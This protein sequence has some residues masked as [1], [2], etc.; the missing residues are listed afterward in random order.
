[1][2]QP[3]PEEQGEV[4]AKEG[5]V[6]FFDILGYGSYLKNDP[7]VRSKQALRVLLDIKAELPASIK[8]R[9][10]ETL[11]SHLSWNVFSDSI[12]LAMPCPGISGKQGAESD[13]GKRWL[14]FLFSS[15]VL[16]DHMF[17]QGLPIRGAIAYGRYFCYENCVAGSAVVEAH[18]LEQRINLSGG[19]FCTRVRR[20]NSTK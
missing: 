11:A 6:G 14:T 20:R 18:Q 5:I 17:D 8:K 12:L 15:V 16:L 3:K 4:Q 10:T 9:V 2:S 19:V 1:M 7:D 13:Q